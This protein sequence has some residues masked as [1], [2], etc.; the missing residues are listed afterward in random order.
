MSIYDRIASSAMNLLSAY[1]RPQGVTLIQS[2]DTTYD[3]A[4]ST[5]VPTLTTYIG[6][7]ALLDYSQTEPAISTVRGTTV[8]QGDKILYLG[9]Q[10]T[11]LGANVV[12]PQPQTD[13]S[14]VIAGDSY[15][16]EASTTVNPG[17]TPVLIICH[18]RGVPGSG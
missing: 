14:I 15:N 10:G 9:M 11:L 17:G 6:T 16:V 2:G 12:M 7:G 1:G 18:L 13:D 3:A 8:E 4:T 5:N